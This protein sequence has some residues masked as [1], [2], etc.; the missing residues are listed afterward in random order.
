V[1][2]AAGVFGDVAVQARLLVEAY[3][4]SNTGML[5]QRELGKLLEQVICRSRCATVVC[6]A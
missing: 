2:L 3:D 4:T 1:L 5:S 6:P